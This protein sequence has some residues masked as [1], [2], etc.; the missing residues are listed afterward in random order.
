MFSVILDYSILPADV[1]LRFLLAQLHMDSLSS[2]L[3]PG[4]IKEVLRNMPHGIKG[5]DA[6][7]EE[8]MK[9]IN[10]QEE[11]FRDLAKQVLS[12]VTHTKRPLTIAELQH[13]V[14]VRD[15]AVELD[16]DFVPD[17]EDLTSV[18]AGLVTVDEQSDIIRWVHYTTQEYFKRTWNI[19]LPQAQVGIATTCI[20][21]LS[22]R[23][24]E[25][26]FCSTDEEFGLRLQSNRLYD[27]AARNWGHHAL[28]AST[29]EE[30]ILGFLNSEAKV[31]ASSQAMLAS[32]RHLLNYS[33][34][35]P[36]HPTGLHLAVYFGLREAVIVL[37]ERG[38]HLDSKDSYGRTPLSW[39]A[40]SGHEAVVKQL[41]STG[42]V[43]ADSKDNYY[44]QTPLWW[45]AE[46]GHEAVVK[47]LLSTG[48]VDADSKDNYNGRTP[49]SLA[50]GRGHEAVVKLLQL[51][52]SLSAYPAFCL[53]S[54]PPTTCY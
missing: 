12:W 16:K 28:I 7:Y 51:H 38:C 5:L 45:A 31:E 32:K 39:A 42:K 23:T 11:E 2:K 15:C 25:S 20:T 53:T 27:Y 9:R 1:R 14:A 34:N 13:A 26:G 48:K 41:L 50:A 54:S 24:F 21:Y 44:G 35:V 22:F 37:I 30:L 40:E 6:M 3:T 33:Q 46:S 47:L 10:G 36:R 18:C 8:A 49:L 4:G 52:N 17:I 43:D 29:M 19:W